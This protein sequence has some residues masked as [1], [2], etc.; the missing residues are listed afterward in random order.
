MNIRRWIS[1]LFFLFALLQLAV[2]FVPGEFLNATVSAMSC[3]IVVLMLVMARG[4]VRRTSAL[5]L[6][7]AIALLAAKGFRIGELAEAMRFYGNLTTLFLLTPL[8]SLPVEQGGFDRAM[9]TVLSRLGKKAAGYA[10]IS[11]VL[12]FF[13]SIFLNI[14]SIGLI[15]ALTGRKEEKW[16]RV[17][18]LS[19][20]RGFA[21]A[22]L[23]SPYSVAVAMIL[24]SFGI[25]WIELFS[26]SAVMVV[27][28]IAA[29]LAECFRTARGNGDD[30]KMPGPPPGEELP[31]GKAAVKRLAV[32][33]LAL[34]LIIGCLLAAESATHYPMVTLVSVLSLAVPVLGFAAMG[35]M[36]RL[37]PAFRDQYWSA[38]LPGMGKEILLI[39]TAGCFAYAIQQ[40]GASERL[41]EWA[42]N[43]GG[44]AGMATLLLIH[45]FMLVFALV[46]FHPIIITSIMISLL[47]SDS[48]GLPP[49]AAPAALIGSWSLAIV[50]SPFSA[51][52]LVLSGLLRKSPAE[53]ALVW[54]WRYTAL[55]LAAIVLFEYLFF[56][57]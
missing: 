56:F 50:F 37:W 48:F 46:G 44:H 6:I 55:T 54:N 23:I 29:H 33:A 47:S 4:T 19:L 24:S 45:L 32:L 21:A 51:T 35:K 53:I 38:R 26:V 17:Q 18:G 43:G 41:A 11:T 13:T 12:A 1:P 36:D 42:S 2:S 7:A 27:I 20:Q 34:A 31:D 25:A 3:A 28:F 22:M 10:A 15:H 49:L 57:L 52:T 39:L 30:A 14:G 5:L 40:S 9:K 8:L 16:I